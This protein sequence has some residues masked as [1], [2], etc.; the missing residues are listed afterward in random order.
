M[1]PT[2]ARRPAP[3]DWEAAWHGALYGQGGFFA[4][5]ERPAGHFRTAPQVGDELARAVLELLTRLDAALG[6]PGH[7]D[8]VD[9][10]AGGGELAAA[11]LTLAPST[12]VGR[13]RVTGVDLAP[14][15]PRLDERIGWQA[16]L[17][18]TVTG[19]LVGNEWLDAVPCPVVL[20]TPDGPRRLSVTPDGSERPDRLVT[21]HDARWLARW[22]PLRPG[23]RAEVGAT[24]D[25]AWASAVRRVR[26]GAALA[27]DYASTRAERAAGRYPAGTLASYVLGDSVTQFSLVIGLYLS[28][29][30]VG[31][32]L[33]KF[34]DRDLAARF[35]DVELGVALAGGLSAPLLFLGFA[36]LQWFQ[37]VLYLVVCVIGVL[38]GLELPILMRILKE[39]LDF[40]ERKAYVKRVDVDY[41]TDA[42]RYTQVRILECAAEARV[43]DSL[44]E[45]PA[46]RSFGAVLVRSQ[47]I[48]FKKL[49]FF[50]NETIGAGNLELPENE[51]HTTAYWVT[52]ERPLLESFVTT[53]TDFP[54][55]SATRM[56]TPR[57]ILITINRAR[58]QRRRKKRTL[59][60]RYR[61]SM[62]ASQVFLAVDQ[63]IADVHEP[64]RVRRSTGIMR[65]HDDGS[66]S[67]LGKRA[68]KR[69]RTGG[70]V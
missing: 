25:G 69:R 39:H 47:V 16:R 68:E 52:L 20:A 23:W 65:Y 41:Y 70:G 1:T 26:A 63:A 11:V 22:W 64:I 59:S 40:K 5:G 42:I 45:I 6:R 58:S 67:R 46:L 14:R 33:S 32:W 50:T 2:T 9:V 19:L 15:P 36:R 10:G 53:P 62:A 48:G 17:P 38:V 55:A 30:G 4:R 21:G 61:D 37:L 24:R 8:L 31:A 29:L 12:L 51:M 49:K 7:L 35:V 28:A 56:A 18:A 34:I 60:V 66:A 43:T 57:A 13:L 54:A 27:V 44:P 3:L